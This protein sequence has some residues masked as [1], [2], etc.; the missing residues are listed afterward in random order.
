VLLPFTNLCSIR[1]W[2]DLHIGWLGLLLSLT[3]TG[4]VTQATKV[5]VGRPRPDL[6]ARCLPKPGSENT[7][8]FGLV[9]AEICTQTDMFILKDGFRSFPS[10]HASL[11]FAG[12]GFLSFYL[13]G[14]IHLFDERGHTSKA[15]VA[16]T[17]L[18]GATLIAITR[19]MDYRHHWEDVTA[20][21]F[22]G[23]GLAFFAYRQ[24]YPPL[25]NPMSHRPYKLR[26]L[27]TLR[28]QEHYAAI[29]AMGADPEGAMTSE[30][31]LRGYAQ[32]YSQSWRR[33]SAIM[34]NG[35]AIRAPHAPNSA[36]TS[37]LRS[38]SK[39]VRPVGDAEMDERSEASE[40]VPD[41]ERGITKPV[42]PKSIQKIWSEERGSEESP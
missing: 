20:G 17:P 18:I 25:S 12:L 16:L 9:T 40:S 2:W 14:K 13:A 38:P 34:S 30:E 24:Y 31:D 6:I 28:R 33:P 21:S 4:V 22:L 10:G 36:H 29:D 3:L 42:L 26:T 35:T 5:T 1:S 15:L 8:I 19:T 41:E 11:S 7:P 37:M 23:L 39:P 32:R 27:R